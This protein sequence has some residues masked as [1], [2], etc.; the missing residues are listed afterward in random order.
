LRSLAKV[1][2]EYPNDEILISLTS[3]SPGNG[4]PE[5][6]QGFRERI[7]ME[8]SDVKQ[9]LI[10]LFR[11]TGEAHHK[12]FIESD[13]ADPDWPIWY[14]GYLCKRLG[15]LLDAHF[16]KSE[17]VYLIVAAEKE[18]GLRAPGSNWP[19]FFTKFFLERYYP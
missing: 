13:G 12:A 8:D 7:I 18:Q 15:E 10:D 3:S 5:P 19:V 17:L 6:S 14:A 2:T 4:F 9:K 11:E 1:Y 16:T